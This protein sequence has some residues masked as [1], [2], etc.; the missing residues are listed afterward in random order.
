MGHGF[1]AGELGMK[2]L[3][4]SFVGTQA[5]R[6]KHTI[7]SRPEWE[8]GTRLVSG[9][10]L[11]TVS[12]NPEGTRAEC[13][14]ARYGTKAQ[15]YDVAI[16]PH[17]T[18]ALGSELAIYGAI[19]SPLVRGIVSYLGLSR[20]IIRT[21]GIEAVLPNT[22]SIEIGNDTSFLSATTFQE[23]LLSLASG[24]LLGQAPIEEY[25]YIGDVSATTARRLG[26]RAQYETFEP[27]TRRDTEALNLL[28]GQG[29]L[30]LFASCWDATLFDD[31]TGFRGELL[32]RFPLPPDVSFHDCL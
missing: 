19:A 27:L 25:A 6:L 13:I 22:V 12:P 18:P 3:Y 20:A 10:N 11:S 26:L 15:E 29:A 31:V 24:A 21:R 5:D 2:T 9:E 30:E 14:V 28:L 4:N 23:A 17:S 32:G 1:H 16:H 8:T 7:L